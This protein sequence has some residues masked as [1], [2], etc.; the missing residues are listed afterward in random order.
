MVLSVQF[1]DGQ[2]VTPIPVL[3]PGE[4]ESQGRR[5]THSPDYREVMWYGVPLIFAA[6]QAKVFSVLHKA[7]DSDVIWI[8]A[9]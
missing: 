5:V 2:W 8:I 4:R 6:K 3:R 7:F 1:D 9:R